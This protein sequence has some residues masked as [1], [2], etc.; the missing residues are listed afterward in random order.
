MN[1]QQRQPL[2]A[3]IRLQDNCIYLAR[4]GQMRS[5]AKPEFFAEASKNPD[6]M[7]G[8]V[9]ALHQVNGPHDVHY[10]VWEMHPAGDELLI[11][12]SGCL[13]LEFR[14]TETPLA[15][16]SQAAVIVPAGVWHRLVVHEPSVL[17]AITPRF[18]TVHEAA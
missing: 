3:A 11:L 6:L 16:P 14:G 4:H 13:S 9:L 7:T 12:A 1:V 8:R 18:N 2:P 15:L 17:V 10:P 5:F